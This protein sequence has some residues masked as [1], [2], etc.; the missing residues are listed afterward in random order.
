MTRGGSHGRVARGASAAGVVISLVFLSGVG[1]A[2]GSTAGGLSA[3]VLPSSRHTA[4]VLAGVPACAAAAP[5]VHDFAPGSGRTVAL[6]FDD[7]PGPSTRAIL[8]IL[9]DEH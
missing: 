7:G 5:A 3:S 6:T 9:A 8:A 2:V 1:Q 4:R